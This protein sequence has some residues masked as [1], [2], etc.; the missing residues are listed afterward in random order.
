MNRTDAAMETTTQYHFGVGRRK[1]STAR[2]KVYQSDKLEITVNKQDPKTYFSHYYYQILET[3]LTNIGLKQAKIEIYVSGGGTMGQ[4]E[5]ARL[6]VCKALTK[7][8]EGYR[9]VLKIHKYLST[10]IR[11]VLPKRPG[12]RKARKREQW[13]K[14]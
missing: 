14:R 10:D 5:A 6:A 3:M 9:P 2:A 11:K 4:A 12:L 1:R 8:D 13:S 7:Q